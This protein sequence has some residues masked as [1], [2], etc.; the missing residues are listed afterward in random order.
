MKTY[1]YLLSAAVFVLVL[2]CG[3]CQTGAVQGV[4]AMVAEEAT[5]DDT[6]PGGSVFDDLRTGGYD[7]VARGNEP[8]WSL[9]VDFEGESRF[10]MLGEEPLIFERVAMPSPAAEKGFFLLALAKDEILIEVFLRE[11]DCVDSMSGEPFTWKVRVIRSGEELT[12]CG[13]Y[14]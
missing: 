5:I 2:I 14:L 3:G 13:R 9:D 10:L 11:G 8:F 6:A 1:M 7:F 12:G 4:P